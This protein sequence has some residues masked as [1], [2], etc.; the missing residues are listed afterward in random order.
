MTIRARDL[1][2]PFDG[3]PGKWNAIT[4]VPGVE[5]GFTT[6]ISGDE[7]SGPAVRT[8]VTAILPRGKSGVG[9]PC[10]AA[11]FTLNGNG[12]M[13]GRAWIDESGSLSTP[14]AITNSHSVGD[15]H[16]GVI[17]WLAQHNP[18]VLAQWALP[19]V[20]ET[21]DGY[22]NDT[23]GQHVTEAHAR[24]ALDAA[25][26]GPL[27][28]GNVGGGT[29]MNCYGFKGGT[30]TSS[31][32]VTLGSEKYTVGVLV[33]ANHGSR[34]EFEIRGHK[35]GAQSSAPCPIFETDWLER[36]RQRVRVPGGAGS[37]IVIL[38]TDAPLLPNQIKAMT[39]R[40][41]L[42][43]A[44]NGTTG[45]HFS[46]DIFVGFSTANSGSLSPNFPDRAFSAEG[47]ETLSFVPWGYMDSLF[48]GVVQATEE[49]VVNAMVAATDMTGRDGHESFALPH[50]EVRA[51]FPA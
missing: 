29:G 34:H 32:E 24:A 10:A 25:A 5:V 28:E 21:W 8:G 3:T 9:I 39:R 22:L 35:V 7:V 23:N 26:T 15:V 37:I 40:I 33:Q 6:V 51:I 19:V 12:E 20:A 16:S 46:G 31:R 2:V 4:D 49:A 14:I 50:E 13:T 41:P 18:E 43:L 38:A 17:R 45:S 1:N 42:G 44:R 27:A 36:D 48:D 11:T 30:G 47:L